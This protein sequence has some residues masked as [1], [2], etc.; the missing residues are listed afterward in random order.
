MFSTELAAVRPE[1]S[2]DVTRER[3]H[4]PSRGR[5]MGRLVAV[6]LVAG[7]ILAGSATGAVAAPGAPASCVAQL[8]HSPLGPPGE[9]QRVAHVRVGE[10]DKSVLLTYEREMLGLYV[11][12]HPLFGVEHVIAGATDIP[13]SQIVDCDD[14]RTIVVGDIYPA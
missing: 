9:F 6:S 5:R 7:A 14:G 3:S 12:D 4:R 8:V 13:V 2:M 1:V 10:W 11:S